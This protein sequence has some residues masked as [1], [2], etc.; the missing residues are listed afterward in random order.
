MILIKRTADG[1][2]MNDRQSAYWG[3]VQKLAD[4]G[5]LLV[6]IEGDS[7][8]TDRVNTAIAQLTAELGIWETRRKE[9][10]VKQYGGVV[11]DYEIFQVPDADKA[12]AMTSRLIE[13]ESGRLI[14]H[15]SQRYAVDGGVITTYAAWVK[16]NARLLEDD[17][18]DFSTL[19]L[20]EP[21]FFRLVY[22]QE[23]ASLAISVQL[24]V[25]NEDEE[26]ESLS[27]NQEQL[28]TVCEG[29]INIDNTITEGRF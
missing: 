27:G 12:E 15:P 10:A 22:A 25:R 13:W 19:N 17:L 28:T 9:S 2:I 11:S 7:V 29:R 3:G 5:T 21:L 23:T 4:L 8:A 6:S 1:L 24:L 18:T 16:G 26:F 14:Y 20:T